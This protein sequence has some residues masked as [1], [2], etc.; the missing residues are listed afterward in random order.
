MFFMWLVMMAA[1]MLPS[2]APVILLYTTIAR[3]S[4]SAGSAPFAPSLF[5]LGYLAIWS[6]F[7]LAAVL[8]QFFLEWTTLL[9]PMME[10]SSAVLSGIL[11]IGAG[12]YQFT[13]LKHSCLRLCR[14]PLDFLTSHWRSG[15]R[16]AFVMGVRHGIYCLGYCW[17]L[18]L[19][20]FVGGIMNLI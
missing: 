1:M 5:V 4:A 11:L 6:V 17:G 20:L 18:M 14:S 12:I 15:N 2:A 8:A 13:P 7:S 16:G 19:L 10:S 3:R 9:S